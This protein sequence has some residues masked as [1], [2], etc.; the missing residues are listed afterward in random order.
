MAAL[1]KSTGKVIWRSSELKDKAA[2]SSPI[3]GIDVGGI[4]QYI[5]ATGKAVVGVAAKDGKLLWRCE[6]PTF[7]VA[8]IP[9][10]IFH[11]SY[12]FAT[13]GY[14]AGCDLIRLTA[15]NQGVKAEPV[16]SKEVKKNMV[17]HHGGVVLVGDY[18][19]GYSDGKGWVCQGFQSGKLKWQN[20]ELGKGSVTFADGYLYCYS[21]DE[22]KVA[23]VEANPDAWKEHGRFKIPQESKQRKSGGRTWTHPV[24]ANGRL[25]IRDQDLIFCFDVRGSH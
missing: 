6:E 3:G 2:Y 1:D 16:Y 23:L 18:L 11:D 5:Q 7:R 17:N 24:V 13:A 8:V 21:E 10:P 4:R 15:D 12:V 19:Y 25:Y 14:G 9:T 22:G 20:K